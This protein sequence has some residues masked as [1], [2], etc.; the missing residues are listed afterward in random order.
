MQVQP[1]E[2][3]L[4]VRAAFVA[5]AEVQLGNARLVLVRHLP[6]VVLSVPTPNTYTVHGRL[7]RACRDVTAKQAARHPSSQAATRAPQN[8]A[9]LVESAVE[10]L[11]TPAACVVHSCTTTTHTVYW[12]DLV[13]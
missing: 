9:W 1:A 6:V 10:H 13:R 11:L 5:S 12:Y 4:D 3:G 2:L 8:M 7:G